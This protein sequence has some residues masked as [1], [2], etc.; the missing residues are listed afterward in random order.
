MMKLESMSRYKQFQQS[1]GTLSTNWLLR[2]VRSETII[3]V[4]RYLI[5]SSYTPHFRFFVSWAL[6]SDCVDF[7]PTYPYDQQIPLTSC[8]GIGSP[9]L[10]CEL[11]RRLE[12][13]DATVLH[14]KVCHPRRGLDP[15]HVA[16]FC[17]PTIE[18]PG[19]G[20]FINLAKS[21]HIWYG[22]DIYIYIY[23]YIYLFIYHDI[24]IHF[25]TSKLGE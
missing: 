18:R 25:Q 6:D 22:T 7:C 12:V 4:T 2:V 16:G 20:A 1:S 9:I 24:S 19:H 23:M 11:Q 3:L 14:G 10:R 17:R 21:T 15:N 5:D 13:P 8:S